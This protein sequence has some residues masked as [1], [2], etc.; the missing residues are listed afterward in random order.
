MSSARELIQELRGVVCRCGREKHSGE[1]FCKACYFRLPPLLRRA[2]Y[3][4]VGEG[5]ENAYAEAC[6]FLDTPAP[7][8]PAQAVMFDS[9]PD[10]D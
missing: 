1:T 2:L 3:K 9:S 5:Y 8:K 6:G 7:K 4:R 10:P